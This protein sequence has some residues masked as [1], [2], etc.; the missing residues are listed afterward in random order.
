M[1]E[2]PSAAF[3][4]VKN[5]VGNCFSKTTAKI[6][7]QFV[8]LLL[9]WLTRWSQIVPVPTLLIFL[10]FLKGNIVF[11]WEGLRASYFLG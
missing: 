1:M 5:T 4:A 10:I 6:S 8:V 7:S 11:L 9:S 2:K 3:V